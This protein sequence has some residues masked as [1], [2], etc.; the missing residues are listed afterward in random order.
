MTIA[1]IGTNAAVF[2][3]ELSLGERLDGFIAL[4]GLTPA[5]VIKEFHRHSVIAAGIPFFTSMFL[6]GGWFHLIGNML[7]LWVFG[8]NVEDSLG[9]VRFF[10][11]YILCGLSAAAAQVYANPIS[12]ATMI[13]ASGAIAGILGGYFLLYPKARIVTLIPIFILFYFFE[14]PAIV[15]LGFWFLM[16]FFNGTLALS[17]EA[18]NAGGVAWWAHVGGF[19]SGMILVFPFRKANR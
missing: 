13:G 2:A 7:Y 8:D 16:Q 15:F 9:H 12:T 10:L 17:N 1:L 18:G 3:F 4:F 14:I 11:F 6:H 5:V 19:A